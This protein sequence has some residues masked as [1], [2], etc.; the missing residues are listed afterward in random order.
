LTLTGD[1]FS[2]NSA[3]GA[4]GGAQGK[5]GSLFIYASGGATASAADVVF[6][7]SVAAAAGAPGVGYSDLP[8]VA[9]NTCPI[10]DDVNVCGA[11][12]QISFTGPSSA[13]YRNTI[14]TTASD[15]AN[16]TPTVTVLSGPCSSS[17][18]VITVT[19]GNG[20]CVLQAAWPV[21]GSY[22][23]A[24]AEIRV[25]TT[26]VQVTPS[27]TANNKSY[28]GTAAATIASCTLSGV[29]AADT[30]NVGCA[31]ASASF[32]SAGPGNGIQVTASGITL[33]GSAAANYALTSTTATATASITPANITAAVTITSTALSYNRPK[34]AGT[35]ILTIRNNTASAI[36]GPLEIA[37]AISGNA[38]ASGNAGTYQAN[39]YW[40]VQAGTLAPGASISISV[41]FQYAAG[42][43]FTTAPTVY[44][45]SL[46]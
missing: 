5:G 1:T 41:T 3:I 21:S 38:V 16:T 39:P 20:T 11:L 7:G 10:E 23:A 9:G 46:Q 31:A 15:N 12:R 18:G 42:T 29:L 27:I 25:N 13:I 44:S 43:A 30:G 19:G 35:E 22:A 14:T 4:S 24:S 34:A 32:A 26:A 40:T 17:G 33:T 2:G 36:A 6:S 28:N 37:L 45:G 8:Y